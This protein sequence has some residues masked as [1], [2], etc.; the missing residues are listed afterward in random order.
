MWQCRKKDPSKMMHPTPQ[1]S[2]PRLLWSVYSETECP[3]MVWLAL[4]HPNR[5]DGYGFVKA[6]IMVE[7]VDFLICL[8]K[9]IG[10][11]INCPCLLSVVLRWRYRFLN[12]L[13][14]GTTRSIRMLL[15]SF[16]FHHGLVLVVLFWFPWTYVFFYGSLRLQSFSYVILQSFN[17]VMLN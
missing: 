17:C 7:N 3:S 9:N 16:W 14:Q 13:S 2:R 5:S 1:I 11:K 4:R 12:M 10:C 15:S 8:L 6:C